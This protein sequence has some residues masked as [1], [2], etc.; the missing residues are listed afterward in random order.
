[1][2]V[3]VRY[4]SDLIAWSFPHEVFIELMKTATKSVEFSFN[5]V[6]YRQIDGVAIGSP[7][8]LRW[9]T[10]LSVIM[11]LYCLEE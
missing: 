8:G 2:C 4:S 3:D 10:F 6:I 9:L 5:S 7:L 11:K 1:M